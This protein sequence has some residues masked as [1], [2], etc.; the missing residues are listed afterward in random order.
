MVVGITRRSIPEIFACAEEFV[1]LVPSQPY[2][3][4]LMVY[5][6]TMCPK[7]RDFANTMMRK[8]RVGQAGTCE[9]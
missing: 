8:P 3:D 5:L 6:N 4:E 1:P 2:D 7:N 9:D